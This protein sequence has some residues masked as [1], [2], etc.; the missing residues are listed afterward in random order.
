MRARK[1]GL[2]VCK[3]GSRLHS[4]RQ[5][6]DRFVCRCGVSLGRSRQLRERTCRETR[7]RGQRSRLDGRREHV[8]VLVVCDVAEDGR[9]YSAEE[10]TRR[11]GKTGRC[12]DVLLVD[13]SEADDDERVENYQRCHHGDNDGEHNGFGWIVERGGAHGAHARCLQCNCTENLPPLMPDPLTLCDPE[14]AQDRS[15]WKHFGV[16]TL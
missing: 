13:D 4:W 1:I 8:G 7:V 15:K 9:S 5:S 2:L 16:Q 12:A 14:A 6:W 3:H 10:Q 11:A